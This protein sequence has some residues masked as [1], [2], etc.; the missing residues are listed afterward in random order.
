MRRTTI[1]TAVRKA[2]RGPAAPCAGEI[3][4]VALSGGPDSVALT[5][6]LAESAGE[7]EIR[8]VAAH[9]DHGLR[10]GSG[11]DAVF[12][13]EL[14]RRLGL[15]LRS[16]QADVRGRAR[17]EGGGLEEAAR[18]ERYAFLRSVKKALGASTIAVAHTRDDQAETFLLRLLRGAGSRGL[19]AMRL[20]SGDLFRPLLDVSR[21]QVLDHLRRRGLPWREDPSNTDPSFVRNRVRHELLPYLEARF[22]PRVR[23]A[24]A[25]SAGLIAEEADVIEGLAEGHLGVG[26]AN[27]GPI[28]LSRQ[29]LAAAPSAV[30]RA[31]L[32]RAI[33]VTGG[34]R[35]V[36]KLH[37]DRLLALALSRDPSRRRVPLPGG[38]EAVFSYRDVVVGARPGAIPGPILAPS[39]EAWP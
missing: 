10:A 8:V 24:L 30:A 20:R 35:A 2:L 17:R 15:P 33:E 13:A 27:A 16:G 23:A 34:L 19:G 1:M 28:V 11:D 7:A 29:A 39:A 36:S 26:G 32:R 9:L 21:D 31:A 25:R 4:V 14:C 22:N 37:V 18:L 38:R 5:D 12:C 6:A 3:V